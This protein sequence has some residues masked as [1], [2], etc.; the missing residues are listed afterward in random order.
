MNDF[1][2]MLAFAGALTYLLIPIF[3]AI[4]GTRKSIKNIGNKDNTKGAN[5]S[6]S[7]QAIVFLLVAIS[8]GI[9]SFEAGLNPYLRAINILATITFAMLTISSIISL[10][11]M[12][13]YLS[14]QKSKVPEWH[15]LNFEYK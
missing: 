9:I 11:S 14:K 5:I 12:N 7:I 8:T 2:I 15:F 13:L 6:V 3:I 1:I 4:K 10:I